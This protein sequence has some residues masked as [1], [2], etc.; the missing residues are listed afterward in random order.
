M[1]YKV[2]W[3]ARSLIKLESPQYERS[4]KLIE[5]LDLLVDTQYV[6]H[7]LQTK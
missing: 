3:R 7:N 1:C 5:D 6:N 2:E 4:L